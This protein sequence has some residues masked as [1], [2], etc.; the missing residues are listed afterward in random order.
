MSDNFDSFDAEVQADTSPSQPSQAAAET[1]VCIG[2]NASHW[3][4]SGL[5]T[6][7]LSYATVQL[8]SRVSELSP[9]LL[10]VKPPNVP[11]TYDRKGHMQLKQMVNAIL[12]Q[13]ESGKDVLVVDNPRAQ[14]WRVDSMQAL[15]QHRKLSSELVR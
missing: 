7:E 4:K 6:I 8:W 1:C 3:S 15:I 9:D 5:Q 13:L 12:K 2:L 14:A 11:T 10:V